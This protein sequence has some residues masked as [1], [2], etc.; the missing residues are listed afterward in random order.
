MVTEIQTDIFLADADIIVHQ[1][2]CF[3]TMGSGIAR[4][5]RENFPEAYEADLKTKK[6]DKNKLGTFSVAKVESEENPRLQRIVNLYSQYDF[7]R[8]ERHTSYDAMDKG[9]R[10]LHNQVIEYNQT[11]QGGLNPMRTI[12]IP[13]RI[14]SNLGGGDW[15]VVRAII[16]AVFEESPINVLICENPAISNELLNKSSK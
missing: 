12:A 10:H 4:V 9:L 16:Y 15:K 2:N 8:Q 3:H 13:W 5:I 14:G 7:G 11:T 6:G 1:A